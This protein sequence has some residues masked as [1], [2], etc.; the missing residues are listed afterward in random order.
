MHFTELF[1]RRP[2]LS[3][4]LGAFI[5][6]LGAYGIL[7]LPVRQYPEVE[8]T[9]VTITTIY[10]GA[11]PDLIQ[12]FI[13]SPIAQAVATT[14]NIDYLTSQ[15]TPSVSVVSVNMEL[16]SDPD[17]AL[18]EVLSKV[19]QVRGQLP[20]EAEDPVIVKGTGMD[21]A[22]MYLA[23]LNPNMTPE[24]LTEYLE[25]V[26]RPRMSTIP[27]VAEIEIIGAANYAMRVWLD[28]MQLAARGVTATDVRDAIAASNFLSAPGKTENEFVAYNITMQSTLQTPE[29]FGAL[30]LRGE[31]DAVVRLRDVAR[32]ELASEEQE[33]IVTFNGESGTFIGVF[34][35][36]AANP[37]DTAD[38]VVAELPAINAAL[39]EGMEISL[40]Y[41]FDRADQRLD[42]GGVQDHRRGGGD[43]RRRHPAVPRL[44]PLGADAG[45]HHPAVA[46]RRLRAAA[47]DGLL[48]QP[49]V[50]ARD[51]AGDR[52]RRRRRDRRRREHPPPH[53]GGAARR[54]TRRSS[55]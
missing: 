11:P 23:A 37:L 3:T 41:D 4:V 55:A 24:Q 43:R 25:R 9:V 12:G 6:L 38:A 13:T 42:R 45:R 27:G 40:V 53:R 22:L 50:A 16:G 30:P 17:V 36:P 15:S 54:W 52:P 49:P 33:E 18:T 26:I 28:P 39:P 21:F 1:I 47:R 10:P 34:P 5:L 20:E 31:G 44:V 8:E 7:N 19:Q 48:D 51:G 46:D 14:E 29:A 2:V 32:V 35:T